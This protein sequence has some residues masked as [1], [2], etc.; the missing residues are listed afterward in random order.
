MFFPSIHAIAFS[1]VIHHVS[2]FVLDHVAEAALAAVQSCA[3][4]LGRSPLGS[5][6]SVASVLRGP[7]RA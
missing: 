5:A 1:Q 6:R 3:P 7:R 2:S 4:A